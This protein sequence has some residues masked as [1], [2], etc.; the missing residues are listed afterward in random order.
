MRLTFRRVWVHSPPAGRSQCRPCW[1]REGRTW[2]LVLW[3][4]C[5][6]SCVEVVLFVEKMTKVTL[7]RVGL[8]LSASSL[9]RWQSHLFWQLEWRCAY[10]I[11]QSARWH[12]R[13]CRTSPR[14]SQ[15]CSKMN[16]KQQPQKHAKTASTLHISHQHR[17]F[18]SRSSTSPTLPQA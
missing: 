17:H 8:Q 15:A 3:W 16:C 5:R 7:D 18:T 2:W 10:M 12:A 9:A 1:S 13:S 11:G 6:R 14:H 4:W